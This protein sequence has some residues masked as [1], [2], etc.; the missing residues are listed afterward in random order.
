MQHDNRVIR[1][2]L[3]ANTPQGFVSRFDQLG[4]GQEG[5]RC[6]IMKGGP[7]TGKSTIMKRLGERFGD[8]SQ[9][10]YIHCAS[11]THSLDALI[12]KDHKLSIADGT[13][14]HVLEPKYP[15]ACENIVPLGDCWDKEVLFARQKEIMALTDQCSHCHEHAVRFLTAAGALLGDT[16]RIALDFTDTAKISRYAAG[17][18]ARELKTRK[19]PTPQSASKESVRFLSAVT[20]EDICL[21]EDTAAALCDRVYALEDEYGAS[22]RLLLVALRGLALAA[23]YDIITCYCPLSP[24]DKIEHLFIPDLKLGFMTFNRFHA[25]AAT[26]YRVVNARRFTDMEK[27][28]LRKKRLT[29]NLKG[30]TQMISEAA[31]LMSEAK[32]THD[33]LEAHYAAAMDY[34]KLETMYRELERELATIL[35]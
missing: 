28:G 12:W 29:Y 19:E 6:Y 14:P 9:L 34:E 26:P 11:D 10:E 15:G 18:A 32:A 3:G 33:Q 27:L 7:G 1:Y 20:N 21:F 4:S 13:A 22:S 25:P 23:G 31:R 8:R 35:G 2:F 17:V 5:W 30:A 24:F 16:Y